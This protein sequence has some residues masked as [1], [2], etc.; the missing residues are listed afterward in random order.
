MKYIS[1][2]MWNS[3]FNVLVFL[4][5]LYKSIKFNYNLISKNQ[6]MSS[7]AEESNSLGMS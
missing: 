2:T 3:I 7:N 5:G 6:T 1:V 4:N